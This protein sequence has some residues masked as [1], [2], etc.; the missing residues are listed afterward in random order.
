M[1]VL[2][3]TSLFQFQKGN[4]GK[5]VFLKT[6]E[7]LERRGVRVD[8]FDQWRCD[9]SRYDL[10]HCFTMETTNMWDFVKA[11]NGRL[12]VTPI[13]WFG[14][15][16]TTRSRLIRAV[17]RRLRTKIA[18]PLHEWWEGYFRYPDV[19]FPQ[20]RVQADQLA[21]A[22]G[23]PADRTRVVYHG[24]DERF[25]DASPVPFKDR[26][27]RDEFV[28]CVARFEPRK[29]QLGLIRALRGTG[30]P[31]VFIGRPDNDRFA[32]Y[33][34]Q[35]VDEADPS[36]LFIDDIEHDS[37]L[38]RSAYAAARVLVLPSHLEFPGLAALE[39]G[40]AGCSLA[41][42]GV[43]CAAE[44]LG[45][46]ATYLDPYSET[47]IRAAVL[48]AHARARPNTALQDH[49]R[50]EFLWDTVV[51]RNVEGYEMILDASRSR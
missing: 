20:S 40:L 2:F 43:G 1:N 8:L 10:V 35:C 46:R 6:R 44:Y 30:L 25:A 42:T 23:V 27:G 49:I 12:A 11:V 14:P 32:A 16:A 31:L 34:R 24:V 19:F 51:R 39:A 37:D 21:R 33:Y 4:G 28:L 45:A 17:K 41:V 18:C 26:F 29:N 7:A 15:Y 5:T 13:S 36:A 3:H 22:F 48:D 50:R 9:F 47:S 38:M